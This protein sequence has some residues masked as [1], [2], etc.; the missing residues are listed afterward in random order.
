[1]GN[2]ASVLIGD[3]VYSRAFKMMATMGSQR[4]MEIMA[5][6]TTQPG[7]RRAGTL[8]PGPH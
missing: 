3:F 1:L 2:Q 6:A 7:T 5:D 8:R 4:V